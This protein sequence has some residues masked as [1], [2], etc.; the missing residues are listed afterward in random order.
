M[1]KILVT[2][3]LAYDFIMRFGDVFANHILPD[4][5][6]ILNVSFTAHEMSKNL[7]GTGGNI[8]YSLALLEES[9]ILFGTVGQ[10]FGEYRQKLESLKI[11]THFIHICEHEWT[12]S[13]HIITDR[14]DNQ[15]TAFYGGAMLKNDISL[16]P[17]L[18]SQP[19]AYAVIAANGRDGILRYAR[20]LKAH[21]IPYIYDP[22]QSLPCFGCEEL[23]ELTSNAYMIVM[24]EYEK[25][26][27]LNKAELSLQKLCDQV[28]YLIITNGEDGSIIYHQDKHTKIPAA[29][30]RRVLDPTGAGDA[31]RGGLLKGMLYELPMEFC[32]QLGSLAGCYAVE[33]IGTQ[34][35]FYTIAEFEQRFCENYGNSPYLKQIFGSSCRC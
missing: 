8:A 13:A 3:S 24:N 18:E 34:T 12:A 16:A 19:I 4:K 6:H 20:E 5:L 28:A 32:V 23:R 17:I 7:G 1:K 35:Y 30:A 22:G 9:P 10:D 21:K 26:L 29:K 31:F 14:N 2:G 11:D 25:Q 15:I 27:L 33:E